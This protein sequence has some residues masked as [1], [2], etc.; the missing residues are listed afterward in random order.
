MNTNMGNWDGAERRV[1]F[2]V[3]EAETFNLIMETRVAVEEHKQEMQ[4]Q[5]QGIKE[6]LDLH[7]NRVEKL[8][9]ST[10]TVIE[11]QNL[12]IRE[13]KDAFTKAFPE[14]DAESHRKAHE[15]WIEKDKADREFWLK[16]KQNTINWI[17]IAILSWVGLVVWGAFVHGP[18]GK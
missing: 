10:L 18:G 17:V 12:L 8:S 14:G 11:K 15:A 5:F 1:T 2:A 3:A 6:E 9:E 4:R 7:A 16:L 13:I